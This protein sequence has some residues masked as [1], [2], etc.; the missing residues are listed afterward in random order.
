MSSRYAAAVSE[1]PEPA[2]AIGD[3]IGQVIDELGVEPDLAAIFVTSHFRD[4]LADMA[5][6]VQQVLRPGV[7][8]GVTAESIVGGPREVEESPGISLWAGRTGPVRAVRLEAHRDE[9]GW[10]VVGL[11]VD[12]LRDHTL[13]L[14]ADP[15]SFPV[16]ALLAGLRTEVPDA[17]IIGGLGIVRTL[18]W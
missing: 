11:S 8:I 15:Y 16:D 4:H 7:L 5:A 9:D 1:H 18:A 12:E 6:A 14:L 17:V 13:V 2:V 10:S 3:A